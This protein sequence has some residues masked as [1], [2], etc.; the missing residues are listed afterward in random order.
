VLSPRFVAPIGRSDPAGASRI[1]VADTEPNT[2]VASAC[3]AGTLPALPKAA[4]QS[5]VNKMRNVYKA[6]VDAKNVPAIVDYLTAVKG[7]K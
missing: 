7:P 1:G 5:E 3:R 4:W 6:P 2:G